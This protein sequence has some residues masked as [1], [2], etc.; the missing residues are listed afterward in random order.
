MA[1]RILSKEKIKIK[2]PGE[3]KVLKKTRVNQVNLLFP[4]YGS[5][6]H[7]AE[8]KLFIH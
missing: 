1:H 5:F 6:I 3:K 2:I 7:P 8:Q 4:G